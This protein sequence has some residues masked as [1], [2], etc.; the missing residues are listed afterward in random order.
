MLLREKVGLARQPSRPGPGQSP[1]KQGHD[2]WSID[3]D[4]ALSL[5]E[6][7]GLAVDALPQP[8]ITRKDLIEER[9]GSGILRLNP[10]VADLPEKLAVELDLSGPGRGRLL[11]MGTVTNGGGG[12]ACGANALLKALLSHIVL[13]RNEWAVVDLEAGV[14]HLGRGT[15]AAVDGL[16]IVTEPSHRGFATAATISS[17]AREMG[18]NNQL[19]VLNRM[20]D[21]NCALPPD[22]PPVGVTLPVFPGLVER[23]LLDGSVLGLP[24]EEQIDSMIEKMLQQLAE[25]QVVITVDQHMPVLCTQGKTK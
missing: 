24:E 17:I 5:G 18:L 21:Q 9:L 2:V 11:V 8:L 10:A 22:L 13:E 7:V 14:E 4:T 23:Q 15:V 20:P 12:C 16:V 3:A 19:L 25:K 6:A 1:V